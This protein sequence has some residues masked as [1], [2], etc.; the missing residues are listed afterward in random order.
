MPFEIKKDKTKVCILATG[1]G[2]ELGPTQSEKMIYAL[3]DYVSMEKYGVKPDLLFIMDI[4]DEKPQIVSGSDNLGDVI[5]RINNMRIPLISPYK[6]EEIPLSQPFPLRECAEK[7]GQP[8]FSNTIAYMIAY[9]LLNG[10]KEIEFYGVNQAGSHEYAE[11]KGGVEFWIGMAIGMGVKITINGK[12]SQ[13]LIYKGRYGNGIL[14]G[15]LQTPEQIF[16]AEKRFGTAI[17][18]KLLKSQ[19]PHSRVINKRSIN[20]GIKT[21]I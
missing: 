4:L 19:T 5:Q 13:L 17:I 8:Y 18:K 21:I 14:Y 15:Y 10:A 12:D 9:A 20:H 6:Y 2:W 7:F 16:E 3:N 11:E 1:S